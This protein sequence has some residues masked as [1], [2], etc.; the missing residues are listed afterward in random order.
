MITINE[1]LTEIL[2]SSAKQKCIN[3]AA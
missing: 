2:K 3:Q 1:Y